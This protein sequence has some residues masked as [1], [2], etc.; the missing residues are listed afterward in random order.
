MWPPSLQR[1]GLR[2][3][4]IFR[5]LYNESGNDGNDIIILH[6]HLTKTA[7]AE[8]SNIGQKPAYKFRKAN[9]LS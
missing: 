6:G 4:R 3:C 2:C 5:L 9:S 7:F 1:M 8:F